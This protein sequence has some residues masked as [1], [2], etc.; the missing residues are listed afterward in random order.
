MKKLLL[1]A[2]GATLALSFTPGHADVTHS[3]AAKD[4]TGVVSQG[5]LTCTYTS[6][7]GQGQ[8]A[9]ATPNQIHVTAVVA[10]RT[11]ELWS[12]DTLTP[13]GNAT[14]DQPTNTVIT[15]KVGPD[16]ASP[17][18]VSGAVGIVVAGDAS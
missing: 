10:G 12:T 6:V 18:P 7:A 13:P 2:I 3:C 11:V 1:A 14:F 8:I 17:A 5:A 9:F 4:T 16:D 15:V